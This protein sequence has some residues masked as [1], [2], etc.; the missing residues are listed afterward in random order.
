[1]WQ[2]FK[3]WGSRNVLLYNQN[4][5]FILK[6]HYFPAQ[7]NSYL[8]M[9]KWTYIIIIYQIFSVTIIWKHGE[10]IDTTDSGA[11]TLDKMFVMV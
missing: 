7:W 11:T 8:K 2:H 10:K 5:I 9:L 3:G 4:I 1:M 6:G